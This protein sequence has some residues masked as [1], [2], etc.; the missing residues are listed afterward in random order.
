M[1]R[2]EDRPIKTCEELCPEGVVLSDRSFAKCNEFL[3]LI[4]LVSGISITR[5][6]LQLYSS[7]QFRLMPLPVYA[8]RHTS[9]YRHPEDT[10]RLAVVLHLRET[11]YFPVATIRSILKTLHPRYFAAVLSGLLAPGDIKAL[12]DA[13]TMAPDCV[14]VLFRRTS[15]LLTALSLAR[16]S[17]WDSERWNLGALVELATK[18][19]SR[20]ALNRTAFRHEILAAGH[21]N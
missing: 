8:R 14:E 1:V 5:R 16:E 13:G 20:L 10:M 3:K 4:R 9:H 11:Y 17:S 2:H 15:N 21:G 18:M 6:T 7:P 19:R 12:A